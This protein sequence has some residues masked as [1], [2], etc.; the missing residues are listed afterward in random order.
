MVFIFHIFMGES[1]N[2]TFERHMKKL[3]KKAQAYRLEWPYA[4]FIVT[5]ECI[6]TYKKELM[7]IF[8]MSKHTIQGLQSENF[9]HIIADTDDYPIIDRP[10]SNIM[11][12]IIKGEDKD[13]PYSV[14]TE[15]APFYKK[16]AGLLQYGVDIQPIDKHTIYV[17][18]HNR[19]V[20]SFDTACNIE[21]IMRNN[22]FSEEDI[23]KAVI[24]WCLHD[25][26]TPSFGDLTM[27]AFPQLKE[28]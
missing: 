28:E 2:K 7:N 20:H 26:A 16:L 23:K 12:Q 22:G 8:Q 4:H 14:L 3:E 15:V 6:K 24:A 11:N 5:P 27:K 18:H 10:Y 25:V 21:L 19:L 9:Y 17:H 1:F 13:N